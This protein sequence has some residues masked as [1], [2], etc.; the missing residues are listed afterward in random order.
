MQSMMVSEKQHFLRV[1]YNCLDFVKCNSSAQTCKV[2]RNPDSRIQ[3]PVKKNPE[4][5]LWNPKSK[6]DFDYFTINSFE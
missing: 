3:V 6:T 4:S 1:R 5:T 2:I